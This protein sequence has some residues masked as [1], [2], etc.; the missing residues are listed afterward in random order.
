MFVIRLADGEE[1]HGECDELT[2]NPATGVLTVCRV[3]GFEE[4]TTHYSPSAWRSVTHR[5]RGVGVRPSLVS[6][7]QYARATLSRFDLIFLVAPLTLGAS[8]IAAPGMGG[9]NAA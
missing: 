9:A 7:A 5:K 1:V 4:T 6:T 2:I 3:D 8:W